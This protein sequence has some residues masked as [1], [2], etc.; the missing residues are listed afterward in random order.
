MFAKAFIGLIVI[1]LSALVAG[2]VTLSSLD[3]PHVPGHVRISGEVNSPGQF[4]IPGRSNRIEVEEAIDLAGG[5]S[6]RANRERIVV[7]RNQRQIPIN[8][9]KMAMYDSEGLSLIPGDKVVV[10][11]IE[12]VSNAAHN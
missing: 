8:V 6:E 4:L 3:E 12:D 2:V 1:L 7:T 5:Y 10:S 9:S 11:R